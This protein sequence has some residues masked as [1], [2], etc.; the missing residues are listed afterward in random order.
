MFHV[1]TEKNGVQRP[2]MSTQIWSAAASE[3]RIM[4]SSDSR[5]VCET[6]CGHCDDVAKWNAD[7]EANKAQ[8]A[9][10]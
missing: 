8:T 10:A 3:A 1:T 7:Q 4:R 5:I 9:V 2:W 6:G